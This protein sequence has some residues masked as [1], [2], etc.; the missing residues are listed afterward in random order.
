MTT[1]PP[2]AETAAPAAPGLEKPPPSAGRMVRLRGRLARSQS[3]FGSALLSL[4]SSGKLDEQT[5]DEIEEI[6]ITADMGAGPAA[7][8]VEPAA[9]RGQ[10]RGH[11]Q[12]GRGQG[13]APR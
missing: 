6:L 1:P 12:H 9:H 3:A 7:H 11:Q 5:W 13:A 2:V 10:G 4:L 8:M